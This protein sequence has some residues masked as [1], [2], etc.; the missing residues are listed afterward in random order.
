M[1][2]SAPAEHTRGARRDRRRDPPSRRVAL[3]AGIFMVL[4]FISIPVIPVIAAPE[5]V[6]AR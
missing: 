5:A 1:T 6:A 4:T 2:L 3:I